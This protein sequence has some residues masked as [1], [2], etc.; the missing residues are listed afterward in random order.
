MEAREATSEACAE[1]AH[2]KG[3]LPHPYIGHPEPAEPV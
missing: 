3:Q 2:G 1:V